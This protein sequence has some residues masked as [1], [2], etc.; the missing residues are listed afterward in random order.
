MAVDVGAWL[1]VVVGFSHNHCVFFANLEKTIETA[2]GN[3]KRKVEKREIVTRLGFSL[4]EDTLSRF[5]GIDLRCQKTGRA[6][7]RSEEHERTLSF[8]HIIRTVLPLL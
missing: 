1:L 8:S 6:P 7:S 2:K 5:C 3:G 4:P